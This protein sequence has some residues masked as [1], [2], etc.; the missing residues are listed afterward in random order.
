[1]KAPVGDQFPPE[2]GMEK[3]GAPYKKRTKAVLGSIPWGSLGDAGA[4]R[5]MADPTQAPNAKPAVSGTLR[6][7]AR[8]AAR[9]P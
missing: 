9:L 3:L 2:T 7:A 1:M 6:Q 8:A 4:G 5:K